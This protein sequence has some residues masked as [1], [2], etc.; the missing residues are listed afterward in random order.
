MRLSWET[1]LLCRRG[2]AYA[3][4]ERLED[5]CAD[6]AAAVTRDPENP[7]LAAD[8][9]RMREQLKQQQQQ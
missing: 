6:Y 5:A 2:A 1:A 3:A 4:L 8:L 7:Q 9:A